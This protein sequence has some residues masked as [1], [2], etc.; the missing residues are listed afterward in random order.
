MTDSPSLLHL[1]ETMIENGQI[2][3]P[4][5]NN[6][7]AKLQAI[8]EDPNF[9][10]K[11]VVALISTDQVL[12]A[13]VL[14]VA[15]SSFYSGL[16]EV[17]TVP[18]ATVRLGA[19]EVVRLAVLATEKVQYEV[20]AP[21]LS[22]HMVPLWNHAVA[23]A[24][25]ARWLAKKLGYADLENEAFI[26]GLLHDVGSLL[27][28]KV[29]DDILN[30]DPSRINLSETLLKEILDTGHTQQ[31]Y[32]L[33]RHWELPEVYCTIVRDHHNDDLSDASNLMNIVCLADKACLQLGIGLEQDASIVLAATEEAYSLGARDILL[34]ELSIMLED[35]LELA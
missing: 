6:V 20:R 3:L 8:V 9:D 33:A 18:D 23:V 4:P 27:L 21:E 34:A 28:I 22:Q 13:E 1:I 24:M 2:D 29:L 26:G 30:D 25:G 17:T 31:G 11:E 35:T 10:M 5:C 19:P 7:T 15:N 32:R 14:R 16:S 12:V